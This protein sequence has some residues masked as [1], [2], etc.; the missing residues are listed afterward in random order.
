MGYYSQWAIYSPNVLIQDLPVH[1][2]T[3][4]VYKNADLTRHGEVV[5]GDRFA[6]IEHLYLG[7]DRDDEYLGSFGQLKKTKRD[8]PELK[9]VI[10]IGGWSRSEHFSTLASTSEGRAIVAKNTI[11]FMKKYQFDGIEIDWQFPIYRTSSPDIVSRRDNDG[12]NLN[13]LLQEIRR[14]CHA[15]NLNCWLQTILAPYSLETNWDA[16][17]LNQ[18]VDAVVIDVTRLPGDQGELAEP[19]SPLFANKGERSVDSVINIL[20]SFGVNKDKM[21]MTVGS[22]A[23]GWEGV[24]DINNG[25]KQQHKTLS[26]GSW[27]GQHSGAT[28]VY[29]QKNLSYFLSIEDYIEYWDEQGKTSYLFNPEKYGGH[30]IA[31]ENKSAIAAKVLYA[32]DNQ[33]AG[34]A[35]R[36]LHNGDR[37]LI[38]V[39]D[40]YHFFT[41]RYYKMLEFWQQNRDALIVLLQ[42]MSIILIGIIAFT[43]FLNKRNKEDFIQR[44]TFYRLQ[45]WLQAIEWPLLSVVTAA[46]QA[47]DKALLSAQQVKAITE[48]SS[49]VL[50]PLASILSETKLNSS[51]N[52]IFKEV[53]HV[54][55]ILQNVATLSELEHGRQIY[56]NKDVSLQLLINPDGLQQFLYNLCDFASQHTSQF[57]L[58]TLHVSVDQQGGTIELAW[59]AG[60]QVTSLNHTRLNALHHQA[61]LLGVSLYTNNAKGNFTIVFPSELVLQSHR[62]QE[63]IAF[64]FQQKKL[65]VDNIELVN[66]NKPQL[67]DDSAPKELAIER[68]PSLNSLFMAITS[69]NLSTAPSK[70]IY[71]GLEQACQ[72]FIDILQQETKITINHHDQ[73]VSR[74]GEEA[75]LSKYEVLVNADDITVEIVTKNKLS[76][77]DQQLIQVLVY[78]TLMVQKA[79]QSLLK[80]PTV[81]S[82]LY[83]LTRFKEKTKYLKAESGYTGIYVQGKKEPRYISM[84]LR[85]VRLYFDE[86]VLLQI[87]RSYLVNPKK[88]DRVNRVSKLKYE[89]I[90]GKESLPISRTFIPAIQQSHPHWF[91]H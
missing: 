52:Q 84:R 91:N 18:Q 75:L 82:E 10:S 62:A 41:S 80:E 34:M 78:Q 20:S 54:Q 88:V 66:E 44:Q 70:D 59:A 71:K 1:L 55:Q 23:V 83:E 9:T 68:A 47:K 39:F 64:N 5:L 14:Q 33:L 35:V 79:I 30:F 65:I 77:S 31:F 61:K 25:F 45:Y 26:W 43:V 90:I 16:T 53:V 13:L 19:Q 27:D 67:L 3:H 4:L 15:Q 50:Q 21:V 40:Q 86:T 60:D 42:M 24:P 69:F 22:F 28:G 63:G 12:N 72:Y 11:A 49:Q 76:E 48:L 32:K 87:H 17:A 7:A 8:Y 89:A 36:Q 73:L 56:W 46:N 38:D 85:T 6:D 2:M 58:I 51:V 37:A 57:E 29:N 74:L 81:L